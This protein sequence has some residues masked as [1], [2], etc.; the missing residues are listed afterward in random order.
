ML[1]LSAALCNLG[2]TAARN[3]PFCRCL[4]ATTQTFRQRRMLSG[5]PYGSSVAA[6]SPPGNLIAA[7]AASGDIVLW[8]TREL[9]EVARL[10]TPCGQQQCRF[11][12]SCL[13]ISADEQWLLVGCRTPAMLLVYSLQQLRL[14]HALLLPQELYGIAQVQLLPD[15]SSVAGRQRLCMRAQA[16]AHSRFVAWI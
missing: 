2:L 13:S 7:A 10:Q 1:L 16:I 8:S 11:T 14:V 12:P 3:M 9:R 5:A 4:A 6:F 15:S